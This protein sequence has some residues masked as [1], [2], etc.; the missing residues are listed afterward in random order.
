MFG[1]DMDFDNSIEGYFDNEGDPDFVGVIFGRTD[2]PVVGPFD[3]NLFF[4]KGNWNI[5]E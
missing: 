1:F 2:K 3:T 5:A 4:A